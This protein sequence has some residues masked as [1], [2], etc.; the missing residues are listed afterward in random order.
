[1]KKVDRRTFL[2]YA[3][4][5]AAGLSSLAAG[6]SAFGAGPVEIRYLCS[7]YTEGKTE[8]SI[9]ESFVNE[10]NATNKNVK[11]NV[12][13]V[14]EE[15][16]DRKLLG[17][18]EAGNP[19]ELIPGTMQS[20]ATIK[21]ALTITDEV[22]EY[23][24]D[25]L[26]PAEEDLFKNF[27]GP[28]IGKP[29]EIV[30]WPAM[31]GPYGCQMHREWLDAAGVSV[32]EVAEEGLDWWK[33]LI[34]LEAMSKSDLNKQP[35]SAPAGCQGT[36]GDIIDEHLQ[37][38]A[39]AGAPGVVDPETN[40]GSWAKE[41]GIKAM[42]FEWGIINS[43]YV[44]ADFLETGDEH[45]FPRY[46]DGRIGTFMNDAPDFWGELRAADPEGWEDGKYIFGLPLSGPAGMGTKIFTDSFAVCAPAV[47]DDKTKREATFEFC[48]FM[49][50]REKQV[51]CARELA[52]TARLSA[53]E[54]PELTKTPARAR[55][56]K[57]VKKAATAKALGMP[58]IPGKGGVI[59]FDIPFKW[60]GK[61][62]RGEVSVREGSIGM[63]KDVEETIKG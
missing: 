24:G 6:T 28:R 32:E 62:Y 44:N 52:P 2:K 51:I 3:G 13:P 10:F 31:W 59:A 8:R 5:T 50:S 36:R 23:F 19:P 60:F 35:N 58:V 63:G 53:M 46:L 55:F 57:T 14:G 12:L 22:E 34:M 42:E 29:G 56:W 26:A 4:V 21:Y 47:E 48:R 27:F 43:G 41:S 61:I 7:F 37:Y 17:M 16:V 38:L 45:L 20:P 40:T 54:D 39:G 30:L 49:T 18:I 25:D 33:Y 15:M 1:M 9:W 11:V